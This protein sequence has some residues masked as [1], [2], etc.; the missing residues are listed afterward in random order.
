MASSSELAQL[1]LEQLSDFGPVTSK[2]MFGGVGFFRAG[3][4]F[5]LLADDVFYLKSDDK[6][7]PDFE[8]ENLES[9]GYE[10][11]TGRRTIMSY[12]R[13]PERVFD[14]GQEMV[15]WAQK[16]LEAAIRA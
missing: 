11:K 8:A 2:R 14:D 5:A 15:E 12:T 4:M 6:T 3:L 10:S 7:M 1:V 9:F 16:A 13:A